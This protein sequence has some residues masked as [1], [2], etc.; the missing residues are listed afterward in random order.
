MHK[1]VSDFLKMHD[2]KYKENLKLKEI[3]PIRIGAE[4]DFVAYPDSEHKLALLLA[5][6]MDSKIKHKI[7]GRMSNILPP[8][9]KYE[10]VIVR[11]DLIRSV[12]IRGRILDLACG[13]SLPFA[14]RIAFESGLVGL[15]CLSGIPGSIAGA[16]V[17]NAGAFGAEIADRILSVRLFQPSTGDVY[18]ISAAEA[19]FGYRASRFKGTD[20]VI[21]SVCLQLCLGD[22]ALIKGEMDKFRERRIMTQPNEPSLGSCF[23]RPDENIY[24][25][26]LI[27]ECGLKG[28]SVGDAEISRKH[29]GFIIN[30]GH[31]TAD[32]YIRLSDHAARAVYEKFGITL[33][34][35]IEIMN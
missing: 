25:A 28:Y 19:D 7:S 26:R 14:S 23:K 33:E 10:G 1:Y 34:R 17:G 35:E 29:A 5:F 11:T 12:E 15:E 3:S 32:D 4:A 16:A 30:K 13:V 21:L 27:D 22:P 6:L 2:V 18:S 8:D 9:K 20:L 24:A 31:A